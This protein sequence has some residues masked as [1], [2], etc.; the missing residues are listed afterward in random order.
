M[1]YKAPN[2]DNWKGRKTLQKDY[3]YQ[4]IHCCELS[5]LKDSDCKS[6]GIL[7]YGVD[8]GVKRNQ[9]RIGAAVGPAA[10]R[11]SFGTLA[12][13]FDKEVSLY[14][15]GDI[16]CVNSDLENAQKSLSDAVYK[17]ITKAVKPLLIGGGHDIAYGH[18]KGIQKACPDQKIGIVNF[19]AHLDLR[20]FDKGA[21]S[22]SPFN[23]I[24]SES[25]DF[26]YLCIGY[27]E[28]SN[29]PS[30]MDRARELGVQLIARKHSTLQHLDQVFKTIDSFS[31]SVDLLYITIDLD[32]FADCYAPGV[33][34]PSPLGFEVDF[35]MRCIDHLFDSK[36][37]ISV[38]LAELNPSYDID[39]RTSKLAAGISYR[40]IKQWT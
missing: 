14:D 11:T 31:S 36:K 1:N 7:G 32:G 24:A 12:D 13:H 23:Q 15:L 8:E 10:F 22:G 6:V 37:V 20:P 19:D 40:I 5:E 9:G 29:P 16:Q 17:M 2:P 39:S 3:I 28:H 38:D 35:A 33:S 18:F 26:H 4:R 27:R 21:H 25:D 30:L 34:A